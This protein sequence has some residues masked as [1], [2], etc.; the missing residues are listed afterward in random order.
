MSH[1]TEVVRLHVNGD[2]VE[3]GVPAHFTLVEALRYG[4]GLT[5]T[6][7]GCDKGDCGACT[8]LVDGRPTLSCI[9]PVQ[10]AEDRQVTTVEG[11][12]TPEA[13]HPLQD[14]FDRHG[15]AQ[16]GF[17]T[18]GILCSAAALLDG[19]P[20]P[21]RDEIREALSGNLCRCTGYT[22]IFVAVEAAAA[23]RRGR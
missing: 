6:K 3:V 10:E 12:A 16:C 11:L 22:K 15:A 5:G 14:E 21:T 8:V 13:V 23:R 7:Q 17:C 18:P 2:S 1:T 4:L 9:L 20:E 19:N